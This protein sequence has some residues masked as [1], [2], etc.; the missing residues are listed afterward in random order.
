[1]ITCPLS[2]PGV[3]VRFGGFH[4]GEREV[5]SVLFRRVTITCSGLERLLLEALRMMKW[6]YTWIFPHG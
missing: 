5:V 4:P 6:R 2:F 3:R 1:M